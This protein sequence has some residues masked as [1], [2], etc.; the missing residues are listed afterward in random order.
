MFWHN[1]SISSLSKILQWLHSSFRVYRSLLR[2]TDGRPV[3]RSS[4]EATVT[5]D[6]LMNLL[7]F[8]IKFCDSNF[9]VQFLKFSYS[10]HTDISPSHSVQLLERLAANIIG[11]WYSF[12]ITF[13]LRDPR[14]TTSGTAASLMLL[15]VTC[16]LFKPEN[17]SNRLEF[18]VGTSNTLVHMSSL[19]KLFE[20]FSSSPLFRSEAARMIQK[21]PFH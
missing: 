16:N 11:I 7:A 9:P 4:S 5:I 6:W 17:F 2:F 1:F 14:K 3:M 12:Q 18:P 10:P 13:S 20:N 15:Q 19:R 8:W 21:R